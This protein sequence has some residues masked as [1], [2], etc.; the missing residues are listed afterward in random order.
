MGRR[1][2]GELAE[3]EGSVKSIAALAA[4]PLQTLPHADPRPLLNSGTVSVI[5]IYACVCE[6]ESERVMTSTTARSTFSLDLP[7]TS[8]SVVKLLFLHRV[9]ITEHY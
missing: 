5:L 3:R 8:T 6:R 4:L 7:H 2:R 1:T 9:S